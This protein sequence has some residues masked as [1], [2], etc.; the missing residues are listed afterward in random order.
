[1][2]YDVILPESSIL[3]PVTCDCVTVTVTLSCDW[4]GS[5]VTLTLSFPKNK[6]EKEVTNKK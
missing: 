5:V 4:G 3:F 1:M 6:R 2:L